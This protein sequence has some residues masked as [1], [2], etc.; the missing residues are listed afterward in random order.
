MF[1]AALTPQPN[2][3]WRRRRTWSPLAPV[4]PEPAVVAPA[5]PERPTTRPSARERA[6]RHAR[7]DV[8]GAIAREM[9]GRRDVPPLP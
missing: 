7:R 5:G 3:S 1:R 4:A 6:E 2:R 9:R 8:L